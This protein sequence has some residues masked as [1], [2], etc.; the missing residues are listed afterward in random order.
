MIGKLQVLTAK[1]LRHGTSRMYE[2][3]NHRNQA[4]ICAPYTTVSVQA[5]T[6]IYNILDKE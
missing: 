2:I 4:A 1:A 3:Q 6:S 5:W